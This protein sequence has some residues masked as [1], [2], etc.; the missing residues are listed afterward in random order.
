[1]GVREAYRL[2]AAAQVGQLEEWTITTPAQMQARLDQLRV[3]ARAL[4]RDVTSYAPSPEQAA[5]WS[6]WA[7]QFS[8]WLAGFEAFQPDWT[9]RLFGNTATQ[10]ESYAR[11][12]DDWRKSL[13]QWPGARVTAPGPG[14]ADDQRE[15]PKGLSSLAAVGIG[16]AGALALVGVALLARGGS[17]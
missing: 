3:L 5:A 6:S 17:R 16:V 10:I 4:A 2:G 9:D 11:S 14:V 7:V 12:I 15:K 1:M 13:A 8:D